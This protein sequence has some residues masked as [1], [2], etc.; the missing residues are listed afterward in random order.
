MVVQLAPLMA[1]E[2]ALGG[3][4]LFCL[5][6]MACNSRTGI[7]Q[8]IRWVMGGRVFS[9][10]WWAETHV[11][12]EPVGLTKLPSP[13]GRQTSRL[14]VGPLQPLKRNRSY[15]GHPKANMS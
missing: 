7:F 8:R 15:S 10:S 4:I 12:A 13:A 9:P 1:L 6:D 5:E 3:L 2:V 14:I 11:R